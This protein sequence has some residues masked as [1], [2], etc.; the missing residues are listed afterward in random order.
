MRVPPEQRLRLAA[1]VG[2]VVLIVNGMLSYRGLRQLVANDAAVHHTLE[3]LGAIDE[4]RS[5]MIDA[6]T[7]ERGFLLTGDVRFLEPYDSARIRLGSA[8]NGLADLASIDASQRARVG[9]LRSQVT[10]ELILLSETV[11]PSSP[12]NL[13]AARARV[14]AGRGKA[15]MD[16]L[17]AN[18]GAMEREERETLATYG[19]ESTSAARNT[20]LALLIATVFAVIALLL[21]HLVS[22]RVLAAEQAARGEAERSNRA[23][24]DFLAIAS[25]ELRTPVTSLRLQI[26]ILQRA[27]RQ[28][29]ASPEL[30]AESGESAA[31]TSLRGLSGVLDDD[32]RRLGDLV[33]GLLDSTRIASGPFELVLADQDFREIV[34]TAVRLLEAEPG[35]AGSAIQVQLDGPLPGRW[36]G[37][38]MRQVVTNLLSNAIR[39]GGGSPVTV[40]AARE[41]EDVVLRVSDGG[42]G[43]PA[44]MQERMFGR[45]ERGAADSHGLGLGLYICQ[46]IVAQHG[47]HIGVDSTPG[48]TTFTVRVPREPR[49]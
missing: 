44:E 15:V 4:V 39:Y 35:A 26:D 8:V 36:D 29:L 30:R 41:G 3:M 25:H 14:R 23:K 24:D 34:Q 6:E 48:G 33:G 5:V 2:V 16:A 45:F 17:R 13:D 9:L 7:G 12:R 19:I 1:V 31:L 27:I 11:L 49:A 20:G 10:A 38:R 18:L 40:A 43:I 22:L 42:P 46:A 32:A 28:A 21:L 37:L 47:G